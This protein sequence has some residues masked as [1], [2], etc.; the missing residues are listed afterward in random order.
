MIFIHPGGTDA[1]VWELARDYWYGPDAVSHWD[2]LPVAVP[3][4]GHASDSLTTSSNEEDLAAARLVDPG[5]PADAREDRPRA[6]RG[7]NPAL[8]ATGRRLRPR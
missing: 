1:A 8:P 4:R 7:P 3:Y 5:V 6:V 2:Q